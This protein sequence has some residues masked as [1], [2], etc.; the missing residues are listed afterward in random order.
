MTRAEHIHH[1]GRSGEGDPRYSSDGPAAAASAAR[2][3]TQLRARAMSDQAAPRPWSMQWS[4]TFTANGMGHV[5]IVD[6][7]HRKIAAVWCRADEKEATAVL[8]VEAVNAWGEV[9]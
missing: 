5:Y 9:T 2:P 4:D 8:I 7:N 1:G 3:Q 6:A